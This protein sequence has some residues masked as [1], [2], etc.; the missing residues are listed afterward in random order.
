M[1]FKFIFIGLLLIGLSAHAQDPDAFVIDFGAFVL[2][3][4]PDIFSEEYNFV[5]TGN[6]PLSPINFNTQVN[7][8]WEP[9]DMM[10]AISQ[11]N[12]EQR[13][14]VELRPVRVKSFGFST[15]SSYS[16]DK[17][18]KVNNIVYKDMRG[19]QFV[20]PFQRPGLCWRCSPYRSNWYR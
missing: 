9:V 6:Y 18:S 3:D 19:L 7:S 5:Y 20:D 13:R 4:E 2:E 17:Q 16:A 11:Q 10:A 1:K 15:R 12:T 14:A 8:Y